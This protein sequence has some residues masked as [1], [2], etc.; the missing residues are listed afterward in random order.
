[1]PDTT[2]P[3]VPR[4]AT[5]P[6]PAVLHGMKP[7]S[8]ELRARLEAAETR[9]QHHVAGLRSEMTVADVEVAGRPVLDHIRHRPWLSVGLTAGSM[10]LAVVIVGLLRRE[11]PEVD[12]RDQWWDAYLDN[13]LNDAAYRVQAGAPPE[14]ALH[15]ALRERAP[16]IVVEA[17]PPRR[18][19]AV[20]QGAS[21]TV[22][23]LLNTVFGFGLKLAMDRLTQELTGHDEISKAVEKEM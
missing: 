16:V 17:E 14:I 11:R 15:Q 18:P 5:A 20:R 1:M 23:T 6:A 2:K 21:S 22:A 10:A 3:A 9:L 4:T 19:S 12:R 8:E 13:F 7:S